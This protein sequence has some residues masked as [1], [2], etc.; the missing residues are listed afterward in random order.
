M[1]V[2]EAKKRGLPAAKGFT[3]DTNDA[4]ELVVRLSYAVDMAVD[5][6]FNSYVSHFIYPADSPQCNTG[7]LQQQPSLDEGK[8]KASQQVSPRVRPAIELPLDG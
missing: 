6:A 3:L 1:L 7:L 2:E 4:G 8:L 5:A